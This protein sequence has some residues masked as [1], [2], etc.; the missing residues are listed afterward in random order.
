[1]PLSNK[2]VSPAEWLEARKALLVKEKELTRLSDEIAKQ[3]RALPWEEVTK[4]YVFDGA[5][6]KET[7]SDLFKNK[8]QLIVYHFM[9]GP[10]DDAGCTGCSFIGD[11]HNGTDAHLEQRDTTWV[12]ISRAPYEKLAKYKERMGWTWKWVS[13]DGNSFPEDMNV[14]FSDPLTGTET[15]NY[16][17]TNFSSGDWPGLSVFYKDKDTGKIYHTYSTY[18]RGLEVLVGTLKELDFTPKGRD[19]EQLGR[20]KM[21]WVKRHDEYETEGDCGKASATLAA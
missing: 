11:H 17:T 18:A 7:L 2:T 21:A 5:N 16:A 13:A 12:A 14:F 10:D 3:R 19:E 1:M 20:N 9:L 8:S 6:G 4:D 15:Y